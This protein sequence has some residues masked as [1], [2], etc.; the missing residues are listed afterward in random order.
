MLLS[1]GVGCG[2]GRMG[3]REQGKAERETAPDP[4]H[5]PRAY[6]SVASRGGRQ[7]PEE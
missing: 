3:A 5:G 4:E 1:V 7:A 6:P 2:E